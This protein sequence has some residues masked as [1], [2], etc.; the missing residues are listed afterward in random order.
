[1]NK[2]TKIVALKTRVL[3]LYTRA[4]V[5]ACCVLY[6]TIELMINKEEIDQFTNN[7]AI[8]M[9]YIYFS[10]KKTTF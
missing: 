5:Y 10:E 4:E 7:Y 3:G 2:K 6:R 8:Y 9:V 1:M